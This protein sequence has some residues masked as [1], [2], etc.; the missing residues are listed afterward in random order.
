LRYERE[1]FGDDFDARTVSQRGSFYILVS[2]LAAVAGTWC[3]GTTSA[4]L[5]LVASSLRSAYWL[6][7]E[8]DDRAMASLRCTLEQSARISATLKN[9]R[10]AERLEQIPTLPSRWLEAAGWKRLS[11]LNG[12]L[13]E[14]THAQKKIDPVGPR[15]LLSALQMDAGDDPE[16]I[17]TARRHALDLVTEFAR[18]TIELLR[19]IS[20]GIAD[21][22][23]K[24]LDNEGPFD[25]SD[26][27]R[28]QVLNHA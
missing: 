22:A 11:A 6:W 27:R 23:V 14:Y 1:K 9:P 7:L 24:L 5:K 10:R 17:M 4:A 16:A 8:D 20:P 18:S 26:S 3:Q 12:A 13:G 2:E 19:A 21:S 15:L 25:L 28:E